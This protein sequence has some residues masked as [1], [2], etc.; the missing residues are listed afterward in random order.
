[1]Y[2]VEKK[3]RVNGTIRGIGK[4]TGGEES[5]NVLEDGS[6]GSYIPKH[7]KALI[8]EVAR[9]G[10]ASALAGEGVGLAREAASDNKRELTA[11][12]QKAISG[13]MLNEAE[14][15]DAGESLGEDGGGV[16]V[17]LGEGEGPKST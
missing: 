2:S 7:S 6:A 16:G 9:V 14:I 12:V 17:D 11:F 4:A 13:D 3:S 10:D 5:T 15:R 1:M 8:P